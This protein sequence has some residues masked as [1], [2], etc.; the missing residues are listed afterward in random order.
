MYAYIYVCMHECML[1]FMYYVR[2]RV[3]NVCMYACVRNPIYVYARM[4][5]CIYIRL[6][7]Y[8]RTYVC[9]YGCMYICMCYYV[10]MSRRRLYSHAVQRRI[11]LQA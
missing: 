1:V 6:H 11:Y 7:M 9:M 3:C 10:R 2:M 8:V 4:C 5:K